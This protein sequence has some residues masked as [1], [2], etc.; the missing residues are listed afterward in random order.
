MPWVQGSG[1]AAAAAQ[2]QFLAWE[3]PYPVDAAIKKKKK[4]KEEGKK[5]VAALTHTLF[6]CGHLW[7]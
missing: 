5:N 2:I 1:A 4:K 3:L 7:K 6:E